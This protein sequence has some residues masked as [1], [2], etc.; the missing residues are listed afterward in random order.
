[1]KDNRR[2][3]N[4][5][6]LIS[7]ILGYRGPLVDIDSTYIKVDI[8]DGE[9][10]DFMDEFERKA[11]S[12]SVNY[13]RE[14][15]LLQN[16]RATE[17]DEARAIFLLEQRY[18]SFFELCKLSFC[19]RIPEIHFYYSLIFASGWQVFGAKEKKVDMTQKINFEVPMYFN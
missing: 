11:Y 15:L 10:L 12:I 16:I 14:Y 17:E 19:A 8:E 7:E 18:N 6:S 4:Q 13:Y 3:E 9:F 1:M 5:P 2:F